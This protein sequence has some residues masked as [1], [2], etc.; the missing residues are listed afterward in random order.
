[1]RQASTHGASEEVGLRSGHGGEEWPVWG[2]S[3]SSADAGLA[4]QGQGPCMLDVGAAHINPLH[5]AT[6]RSA[7]R[8]CMVRRRHAPT[9]GRLPLRAA[10][11]AHCFHCPSTHRA[12]GRVEHVAIP[13]Q[14]RTHLLGGQ[15]VPRQLACSAHK[16]PGVTAAGLR[17]CAVPM[18]AHAQ[19]Q[20]YPNR[21]ACA[22]SAG[23]AGQFDSCP[24][25]LGAHRGCSGARCRGRGGTCEPRPGLWQ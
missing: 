12:V 14:C 2:A 11:L 10:A 17:G 1:M 21:T 9:A 6:L 16:Q 19:G 8:M 5:R 3:E 4:G 15:V 13:N 23:L 24:E 20:G 25:S 22:A 18:G 7:R